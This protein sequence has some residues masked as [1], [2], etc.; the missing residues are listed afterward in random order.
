ME[1]HLPTIGDR[2]QKQCK[3]CNEVRG[4]I[5]TTVNK[6]GHIGSVRC[7][8]CDSRSRVKKGDQLDL[9]ST[10][11]EGAPYDWA[12]TYRKGQTMLHPTFGMGEVTAVVDAGKIDVLFSDRVRRLVHTK[13]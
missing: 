8:Q 12:I 7:P 13:A 10:T 11:L 1:N 3:V 9:S 2:I 6:N 4:H 5:V